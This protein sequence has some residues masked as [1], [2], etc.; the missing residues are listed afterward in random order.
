[1][2][3]FI[4]VLDEFFE[5]R[6]STVSQIHSPQDQSTFSQEGQLKTILFSFGVF[7]QITVSL[8]NR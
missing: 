2:G 5:M 8:E 1:M 4:A 6:L 3:I 7:F